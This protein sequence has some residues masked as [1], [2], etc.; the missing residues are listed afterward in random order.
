MEEI[1]VFSSRFEEGLSE[2]TINSMALR[3][4][5]SNIIKFLNCQYFYKDPADRD[6]IYFIT[7]NPILENK[8]ILIMSTTIP[9]DIYQK[10]YGECVEVID[11]SDVANKGS[12]RQHTNYSY[13]RNSLAS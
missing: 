2:H 12:I 3:D 1:H 6:K 13:S 11:I 4:I 10:M 9:V 7:K 5:D 8:K